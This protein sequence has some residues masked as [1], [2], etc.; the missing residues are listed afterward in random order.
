M[1]KTRRTLA[2]ALATAA[3]AAV[4]AGAAN[5]G[6]TDTQIVNGLPLQTLAIGVPAPSPFV[7]TSFGPGVDATGLGTVLV[8]ST[9]AWS[10]SVA[11]KD[12]STAHTAGH[13]YKGG[14]LCPAGAE[15]E[16]QNALT[17]ASAGTAALGT[18]GAGQKSISGS[19]QVI[20][21]GAVTDLVTNT[22]GMSVGTNEPMGTGCTYSTTLT[23]TVQ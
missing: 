19:D 22:I 14:A 9:K 11:D 5:A 16:T 4:T 15:N 12:T 20:A 18:S 3:I 2:A 10:L 7:F 21:S 23:Y 6:V 8:T 17:I 13:M 1:R